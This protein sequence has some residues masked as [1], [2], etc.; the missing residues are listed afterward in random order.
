MPPTTHCAWPAEPLPSWRF[1]PAC[2]A[3]AR[4][5]PSQTRTFKAVASTCQN[6]A[7]ITQGHK[8]I[9]RK[10]GRRRGSARVRGDSG[11]EQLPVQGPCLGT[12]SA[13]PQSAAA[14]TPSCRSSNGGAERGSHLPRAHEC[15]RGRLETAARAA[16]EGPLASLP[17]VSQAPLWGSGPRGLRTVTGLARGCTRH[18]P[19]AAEARHS[20]GARGF[21]FSAFQAGAAV[22]GAWAPC[23]NLQPA[24]PTPT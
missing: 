1:P 19:D 13:S 8:R 5:V 21:P 9:F 20:E 24:A 4:R 6:V 17:S 22:A 3:S 18:L 2:W 23:P 11:A 7:W 14:F 10:G 12:L 16:P 15:P